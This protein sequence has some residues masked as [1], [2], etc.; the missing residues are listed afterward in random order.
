[1]KANK[2]YIKSIQK[3]GFKA[4]AIAAFVLLFI[5]QRIPLFKVAEL[6]LSN[7]SE[8][9]S[10]A[11]I[12]F[13][14]LVKFFDYFGVAAPAEIEVI[15]YIALGVLA[16]GLAALV[17]SFFAYR[18]VQVINFLVS[19]VGF[20]LSTV[21]GVLMTVLSV[22]FAETEFSEIMA[23]SVN[24]VVWLPAAL[25]LIGTVFVYAYAKMPHYSIAE[26]RFFA[27]FGAALN[28]KRFIRTFG[29]EDDTEQIFR[30]RVPL[31][32]KK[33]ATLSE[34]KAIKKS[35]KAKRKAGKKYKKKSDESLVKDNR[36]LTKLEIALKK[37]EHAEKLA[38]ARA[39]E[40]NRALYK[41]KK[42]KSTAAKPAAAKPAHKPR[43][44][45]AEREKA[46]EA[47]KR[48]AEHAEAVAMKEME[49]S[50]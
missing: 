1:M 24:F 25:F 12:G 45:A 43:R 21:F 49:L 26:G 20:L 14:R 3:L 33:Y 36:N 13:L 46:L 27:A 41:N 32:K 9:F 38:N 31:K 19:L 22:G 29:R 48:R 17:M 8:S 42:I 37:R 6:E 40:E 15:T 11:D 39:D 28:P 50:E 5:V 10:L 35:K 7:V 2:L 4:F 44:S 18:A 16:L 47:A 30:S 23:V 34:P